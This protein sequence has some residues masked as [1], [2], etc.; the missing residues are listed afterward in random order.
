M[1][2]GVAVEAISIHAAREGGDIVVIFA[3]VIAVIS[4][5]AAREGG[6]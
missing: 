2:C 3:A 5:H 4:I 1:G 6:D